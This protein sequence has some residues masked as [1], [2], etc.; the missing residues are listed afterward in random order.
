[1]AYVSHAGLKTIAELEAIAKERD[2]PALKI[3]AAKWLLRTCSDK[4]LKSG[5]SESGP[6]IDR[7]LDRTLGRPAQHIDVDMVG[8]QAHLV[9]LTDVTKTGFNDAFD[10]MDDDATPAE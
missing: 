7:L 4:K 5:A 9:E 10:G 2:S 6:E 8:R 1:M 3:A